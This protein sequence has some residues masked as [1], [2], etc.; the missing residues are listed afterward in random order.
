[1]FGFLS[2]VIEP[3]FFSNAAGP[4]GAHGGW[5]RC[6]GLRHRRHVHRDARPVV[7]RALAGR[8]R[9]RGGIGG[10]SSRDQSAL[11]VRRD[12]SHGGGGDGVDRDSPSARPR[13]RHRHR[14][15]RGARTRGAVP[16]PRHDGVEHDRGDDQRALRIDLHAALVMVPVIAIFSVV[17]AGIVLADVPATA[18]SARS[19]PISQ[20]RMAC[21]CVWLASA[22][23]PRSRLPCRS[24][25]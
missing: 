11:R 21:V 12:E 17:A 4:D 20:R 2:P 6:G 25:Q 10:V 3:G 8:H 19:A 9:D 5:D 14:A 15:R 24:P 16:L 23:S 18:S 22:T 7:C 13:P 1:M